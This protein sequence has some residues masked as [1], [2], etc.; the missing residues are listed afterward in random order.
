MLLFPSG[1]ELPS[2]SQIEQFVSF[3]PVY[4]M[5]LAWASLLLPSPWFMVLRKIAFPFL[6]ETFWENNHD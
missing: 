6:H 5:L 1:V 3:L 2:P 4:L